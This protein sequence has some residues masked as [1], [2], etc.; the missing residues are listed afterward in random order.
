MFQKSKRSNKTYF[1]FGYEDDLNDAYAFYC[2]RYENIPFQEFL[3]LGINEFMRKFKIPESEPLFKKLQS[4]TINIASIKNKDERK[5]WNNLKRINA[6]P[7]E[8]LSY[9]E[10]IREFSNFVKEK[11]L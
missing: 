3:N 7:N 2:A 8:Y 11:K 10:I 6:I 1:C 5:Y 4:R 9:E